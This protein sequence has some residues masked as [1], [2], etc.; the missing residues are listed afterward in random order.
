MAFDPNRLSPGGKTY[1]QID[2]EQSEYVRAANTALAS[3]R[4]KGAC[5]SRYVASHS[6]FEMLV[7]EHD[8]ADNVVLCL[9]AC[10]YVAGPVRWPAQQ[11]EIIWRCDRENARRAWEFEIRDGVAGFRA[12]G[13]MFYWCRGLNLFAQGGLWFGRAVGRESPLSCEQVELSVAKLLR[14]FYRGV[15]GRNDLLYHVSV[16][17]D[18]LPVVGGEMGANGEESG[19]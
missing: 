4:E 9:P 13:C 19:K 5:W 14:Q 6:T 12:I 11:I 8:A 17:L 10:D 7:G 3:V 18:Q 16:V 1:A 2:V 15:M